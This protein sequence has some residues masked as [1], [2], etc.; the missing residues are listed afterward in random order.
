MKRQVIVWEISATCMWQ[1]TRLSD[2][3]I[4]INEHMDTEHAYY[5]HCVIVQL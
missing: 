4:P 3:K 2:V 1:R 5:L